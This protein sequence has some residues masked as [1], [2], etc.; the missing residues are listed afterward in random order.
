M[1]HRGFTISLVLGLALTC[2]LR[3]AGCVSSEVPARPSPLAALDER[4]PNDLDARA[5]QPLAVAREYSVTVFAPPL[6]APVLSRLEA[7]YEAMQPDVDVYV[8]IAPRD[9]DLDPSEVIQQWMGSGAKADVYVAE[10]ISD[11]RSTGIEPIL[12]GPWVGDRLIVVTG[13]GSRLRMVDLSKGDAPVAIAL[14]RTALGRLSRLALDQRGIWNDISY[15]IGRFDDSAAILER[16][17]FGGQSE[18]V[19][20]VVYGSALTADPRSTKAVGEITPP[21]H[22]RALHAI[23]AWTPRGRSFAIWMLSDEALAVAA[24]FGFVPLRPLDEQTADGSNP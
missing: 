10:E 22:D 13:R 1:N 9:P 21:P 4:M 8:R 17:R 12:A 14:E 11:I 7:M 6:F 2:S 15:R 3:L 19:L 20:G 5:D 24:E 18:H 16:A 23:G